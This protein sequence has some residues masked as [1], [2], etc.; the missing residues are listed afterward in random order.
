VLFRSATDL[1][2][3]VTVHVADIIA[4]KGIIDM[5]TINTAAARY[6]S[7]GITAHLSQEVVTRQFEE[8][9]SRMKIL[10]DV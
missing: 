4:H 7:R 8:T 3:A 10:L 2:I 6:I 9:R 5:D 1:N